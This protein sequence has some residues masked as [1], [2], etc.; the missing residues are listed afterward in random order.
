[1]RALQKTKQIE[2]GRLADDLRK[3]EERGGQVIRV[4][5]GASGIHKV[6]KDLLF[7]LRETSGLKQD[8]RPA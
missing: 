8:G 5:A 7:L 4:P 2:S 3:F 6:S 1:M